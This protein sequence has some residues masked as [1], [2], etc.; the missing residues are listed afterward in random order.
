VGG[1]TPGRIEPL[2]NRR[3]RIACSRR[4]VRY[5][6]LHSSARGALLV[7]PAAAAVLELLHPT[8]PDDAIFQAVAP[9]VGWWVTVHVLLL[10]LFPA[11]LWTLSLELPSRHARVE[12]L[13]R[14][15]LL[16]AALGNAAFLAIDGV[17]TAV[18]IFSIRSADA[19]AALTS[20]WNSPLL[21]ALADLAGGAFALALL[22]TAAAIYREARS[23]LALLALMVT[24]LAFLASALPNASPALLISRIAAVVAGAAMVYRSGANAL[25]FA[26]L[27]FA[28]VLPQ[29]VG[30]P[31]ALGMLMVG[32]ALF[33][34]ARPLAVS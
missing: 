26:L 7:A 31:A 5:L 17:G 8:W 27:V 2:A 19:A 15:L 12:S 18:L 21:I 10:G 9:V 11:L 28:A 14:V 34:R 24:G 1:A 16:L 3:E 4:G 29:H 25:P 6:V 30:P 22:A 20:M 13:A 33:L 32:A 23:G